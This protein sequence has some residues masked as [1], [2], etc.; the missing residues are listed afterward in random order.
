VERETWVIRK[1]YSIFVHFYLTTVVDNARRD[2]FLRGSFS[3]IWWVG[4][5][6]VDRES[7]S[8]PRFSAC[9]ACL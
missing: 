2:R 1:Q 7:W 5:A 4:Y 8:F 9:Y 6:I 3:L